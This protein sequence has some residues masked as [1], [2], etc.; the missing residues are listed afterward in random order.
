MG[1]VL[2]DD[3]NKLLDY[4]RRLRSNRMGKEADNRELYTLGSAA[5]VSNDLTFLAGLRRRIK[6]AGNGPRGLAVVNSKAYVAEYFTDTLG[7]V[8]LEPESRSRLGR[9]AL[10]PKPR[11]TV[12]RRGRMLFSDARLCFQ[13]WQSCAS[14]HP[15]GRTD[16]LNW[17]LVND[18]IGNLKN[19]KSLLLA[20]KTPPVMS[21]GIRASAEAAV[22]A[23]FR[24]ILFTH[25]PETDA[26]AIDT[27]LKSA[28][29]VPRP[30][31]AGGQLS[32]AA[33]RGKNLFFSERVG[34]STCHAGSLYTDM[35][36]YNVGSKTPCD[37]RREFDTPALIEVWRTAPY[38]HDGRYTTVKELI[39]KGRHGKER[40]NI[41]L[42]EQEI[43]DLVEFVLSL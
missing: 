19:T 35:R 20:H 1:E 26:V 17:D 3:R 41:D 43:N 31:L 14:C 24:H 11:L 42:S 32:P 36:M 33:K 18:G 34:C 7:I 12:R 23:G 16:G 38:L 39:A 6:L 10:G 5:G 2:Y 4:F 22:R 13:H 28:D 30:Y 21:S 29:P 8:E 15:D 37:R 27:Y 9:L 25:P 40:G